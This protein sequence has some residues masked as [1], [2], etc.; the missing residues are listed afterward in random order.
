MTETSI[1]Q[2]IVLV[3]DDSP[4]SL[5]LINTALDQAGFTVLVALNGSQGLMITKNITPTVI[6]LDAMMPVMDGF[7]CCKELRKNL[8]LTPI[9]FMTGLV[10]VEAITRAFSAGANDYI[11]KPIH[12]DELIARIKSHCY[13]A[14]QITGAR[15]AL[16]AAKQ[17]IVC[18]GEKGEILWQTTE[19]ENI[20]RQFNNLSTSFCRPVQHWINTG[21][22]QRTLELTIDNIPLR[23]RY[24]KKISNEEHLDKI[25]DDNKLFTPEAII[26][27]F[28]LTKR[29]A[30][31]LLWVA[32]GKSNKD[33]ATI[34]KM[35]P[36]TV[37]KHLEQIFPK[38]GAENR[39]AATSITFQAIF[40]TNNN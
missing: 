23:I 1:N 5:E 22:T 31:V 14:S 36:R 40:N 9:I 10:E 8:P 34:L 20:T 12:P 35:S 28:Q 32:N 18:F 27:L 13:S 39:T 2:D 37:N 7:E 21:D 33:I 3:I 16:D 11:T 6:L 29:E 19:A 15:S 24:F 25:E 4:D 26:K 38:I 30:D 17:Y